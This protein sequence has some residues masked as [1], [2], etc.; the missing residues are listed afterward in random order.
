MYIDHTKIKGSYY[1]Q[2]TPATM[3]NWKLQ[4]YE[5]CIWVMLELNQ[6]NICFFPFVLW[7][8]TYTYNLA[9]QISSW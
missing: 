4:N 5:K 7:C 9:H 8:I 1:F 3:Q 2:K 6:K